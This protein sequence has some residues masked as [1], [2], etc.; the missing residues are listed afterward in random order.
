VT[1]GKAQAE[2][3]EARFRVTGRQ[4]EIWRAIDGS[5][6][7]LS[8]RTEGRDTIVPLD[9]G[10]E[11]AFF[12]LFRKPAQTPSRTIAL[13]AVKPVATLSQP[14][15]VRFQP[16][17]GAPAEIAMPTLTAL[18]KSSDPGVRYF[19][20]EATYA[21]SFTLPKG[22]KAGAP[23]WLDLG[24]VGDVAE[25]RVNGQVAGTSWFA[26]YRLDVGRLVKPGRNVIEVKVANLWVNRLIGDQQP[27]AQ[28][29]T[30]TA[31]PTYRPDA[32]LRPSGLIGPVT[33]SA[34]Q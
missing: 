8:Y 13:A 28:K 6:A 26:P 33:L 16:G 1:N 30:F 14:W 31:A 18:D 15:T 2:H 25:V 19:S 32:P 34:E 24:S 27:G 5:A 3:V 4:P 29:I 21:S 22:A 11:D 12:I 20:G 10:P 7:P 23:L 17:R 9:V